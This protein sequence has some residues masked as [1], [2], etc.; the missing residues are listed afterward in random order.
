MPREGA[1]GALEARLELLHGTIQLRAPLDLQVS[2]VL[3]VGTEQPQDVVRE[4]ADDRWRFCAQCDG[5]FRRIQ[6]KVLDRCGDLGLVLNREARV[7]D[8]PEL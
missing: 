8:L 6:P 4:Q 1:I 2:H 5:R 7:T 3:G